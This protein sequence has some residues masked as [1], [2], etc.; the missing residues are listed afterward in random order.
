MINDN[1]I[2][3]NNAAPIEILHSIAGRV[4]KKRLMLGLTQKT[5]A[6]KAGIPLPT[7]RRFERTGDVSL[8][9]L[10]M[11]SI[12]LDCSR[13]FSELFAGNTFTSLDEIIDSTSK[14]RKRGKRN[15]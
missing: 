7:Y 2:S 11:L 4:K 13:D 9:S 10:V 3:L 15:T 12:A 8:R 1:I 5:L 6:D 14:Q